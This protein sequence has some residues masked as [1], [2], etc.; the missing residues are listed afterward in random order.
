MQESFE[1]ALAKQMI[2]RADYE[3]SFI[4]K[5]IARQDVEQMRNLHKKLKLKREE[6]MEMLQLM[7]GNETKLLNFDEWER[8]ILGLYFIR[9]RETFTTDEQIWDLFENILVDCGTD[10]EAD[11]IWRRNVDQA[12]STSKFYIDNFQWLCRSGMSISGVG[13]DKI[14]SNRFELAYPNQTAQQEKPGLLSSIFGGG[15]K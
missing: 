12:N 15:K 2:A 14:L 6:L 11:S 1:D 8:Y 13:F 4:D 7:V 3:K 9:I 10:E 5:L